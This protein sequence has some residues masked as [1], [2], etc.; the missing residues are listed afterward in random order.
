MYVDP[1]RFETG[2]YTVLV[3]A[4]LVRCRCIRIRE[5]RAFDGGQHDAIDPAAWLGYARVHR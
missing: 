5:Y 1:Q 2:R 4:T 3:L